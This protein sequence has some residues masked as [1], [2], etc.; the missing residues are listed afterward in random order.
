MRDVR[1]L[2]SRRWG[3][4][5]L[6]VCAL[7]Y[8][9][10]RL[11]EWQFHRLEATRTANAVIGRNIDAP[12]VPVQRVLAPGEPVAASEEWRHVRATGRWLPE[13]TVVVRYQTR[14]QG[15]GVDVVTPLLTP[16]GVALLVDRGWTAT[17][18][19]GAAPTD[20]APPP[21]GAVTVTGWVRADADPDD[22]VVVDASTR[23]INSTVIGKGL[24]PPVYGG[25]VDLDEQQPV[26]EE[27]LVRTER[28]DLGNGPHFFY[29][30][31]WWF[32]GVL[33]FV[34]FFYLVL[35]EWRVRQ[36]RPSRRQR[37]AAAQDAA[38]ART[39]AATRTR[40]ER[41]DASDS[42]S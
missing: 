6:V 5:F 42:P 1:F 27:D 8:L 2:L 32:F 20:L 19:S 9:A 30:L 16:S 4:F 25:F 34:G 12:P 22:S 38:R 3:L 23:A 21:S 24:A 35:D 31:Q 29:G 13:E 40:P 36:G 15:S 18:N 11:G 41:V 33:A 14:E 39:A 7:A 17:A 10:F 37:R 28:P 26:P